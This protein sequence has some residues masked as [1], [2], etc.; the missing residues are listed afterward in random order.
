MHDQ[1]VI[2][3]FKIG[4]PILRSFGIDIRLAFR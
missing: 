2:V 1:F 4:R 3:Y